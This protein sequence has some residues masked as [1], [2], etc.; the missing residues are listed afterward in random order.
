MNAVEKALIEFEDAASLSRSIM[1]D[2]RALVVSAGHEI[3]NLSDQANLP[4]FKLIA[5]DSNAL[6]LLHTADYLFEH[7][8]D[9]LDEKMKSAAAILE[10]AIEDT[11][12]GQA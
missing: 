12:T 5:T 11:K 3:H 1:S 9:L 8:G 4:G 6:S 2:I 7:W 10:R